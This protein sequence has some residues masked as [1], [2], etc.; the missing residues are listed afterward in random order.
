MIILVIGDI[1]GRPGRMAVQKILP[2][3]RD[4]YKIEMVIAN[5]ENI[6][7][8]I[9]ATPATVNELMECGVDVMTSGNHIW[10]HREI[11]PYLENDMPIIRPLNYPEGVEGKG[12][13]IKD[14]VAV[15]NLIGRT[16]MSSY[17]C[18]FRTMDKLLEK[19][20]NKPVIKI[21]DFHAEATSEKVALG[22]Y[23][24]GRVSAVMGTHTHIGT[25]DAGILPGGTAY[26]TDIGMTGPKESVIGD[27]IDDVVQRFLTMIPNRLSVAKGAVIFT[28]MLLD[29]DKKTGKAKSI[30]RIYQEIEGED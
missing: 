16:F 29:I 21:I 24:D 25:I 15:I 4:Q 23:F 14:N 8:G 3:L 9:G 22:R 20:G 26:V 30:E 28:A 10:A 6:A 19:L 17:D 13:I 18:P 7:G 11:L 12:Y 2:G 1:I 27:N 5:V